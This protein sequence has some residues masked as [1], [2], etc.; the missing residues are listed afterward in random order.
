MFKLDVPPAQLFATPTPP[1]LMELS[2][3]ADAVRVEPSWTPWFPG[4]ICAEPLPL[5]GPNPEWTAIMHEMR[6]GDAVKAFHMLSRWRRQEWYMIDSQRSDNRR[7]LLVNELAERL[8][9]AF[10]AASD[11]AQHE[12]AVWTPLLDALICRCQ[13]L[14]GHARY[15]QHIE[16][17]HRWIVIASLTQLAPVL[18]ARAPD[19]RRAAL[20]E[21][22]VREGVKFFKPSRHASVRSPYTD[23]IES[24][25]KECPSGRLASVA[26]LTMRSVKSAARSSRLLHHLHLE[27]LARQ[28]ETLAGRSYIM[29]RP[30][31]T[32]LRRLCEMHEEFSCADRLRA[33]LCAQLTLPRKGQARCRVDMLCSSDKTLRADVLASFAA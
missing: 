9:A 18:D 11:R 4:W 8:Q 19:V 13:V 20:V 6:E 14:R 25:L 3:R 22:V 1:D 30:A 15:R 17:V 28:L 5:V 27:A 33:V 32:N 12:G 21:V 26:E 24:V 7:E 23:D 16:A 2:L 29:P 31:L 10:L